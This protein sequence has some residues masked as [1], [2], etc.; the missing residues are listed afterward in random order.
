MG[1]DVFINQIRAIRDDVSTHAPVWGA[2]FN[3]QDLKKVKIVST[4]APVWGAM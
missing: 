4:H 2:M 3:L 1:C